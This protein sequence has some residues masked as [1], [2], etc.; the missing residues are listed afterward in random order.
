LQKGTNGKEASDELLVAS[1]DIVSSWLDA[2]VR[3]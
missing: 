2:R 3:N 1:Q